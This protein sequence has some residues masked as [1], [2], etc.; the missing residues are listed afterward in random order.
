MLGVWLAAAVEETRWAGKLRSRS[1]R[2]VLII[3]LQVFTRLLCVVI[4]VPDFV[5]K[6]L[7]FETP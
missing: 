4:I 2:I 5:T 6:R 3:I 1:E 7:E